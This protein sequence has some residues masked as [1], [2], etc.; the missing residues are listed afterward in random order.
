ML[1]RSRMQ[2]PK[3]RIAELVGRSRPVTPDT[4]LRL[5]KVL[6]T[7]AKFWLGL[8]ADYDLER[9]QADLGAELDEI[10]P[11]DVAASAAYGPRTDL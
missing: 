8:Q 2:V 10:E 5:A 4:A 1:F 9:V 3:S 11:V 6:R 7:S